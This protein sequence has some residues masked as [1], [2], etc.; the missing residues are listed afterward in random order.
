MKKDRIWTWSKSPNTH[1]NFY[2]KSIIKE[3]LQWQGESLRYKE[4]RE[5]FCGCWIYEQAQSYQT[6]LTVALNYNIMTHGPVW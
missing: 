6:F 4:S 5:R 1:K 2:N 3:S